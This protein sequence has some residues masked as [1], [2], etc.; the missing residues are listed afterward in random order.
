MPA[1]KFPPLPRHI[2][3]PVS[4]A[5]GGVIR[6]RRERRGWTLTQLAARCGLTRQMLVFIETQERLATIES[7]GRIARALGVRGSAL[8]ARAE[9]RAARWPVRCQKCNYSCIADGWVKWWNCPRAR[10][11]PAH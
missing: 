2:H 11:L 5:I 6:E 1:K 3:E 9:R 7:L 8:L 4:L 10:N